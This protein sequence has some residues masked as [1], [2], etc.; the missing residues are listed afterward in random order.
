M[1]FIR[2][3]E[4]MTT[5]LVR[6]IGQELLT[7]ILKDLLCCPSEWCART[8]DGELYLK[9]NANKEEVQKEIYDWLVRRRRGK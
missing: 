5:T 8:I 6:E 2:G 7:D 1:D 4:E 3:R 9:I